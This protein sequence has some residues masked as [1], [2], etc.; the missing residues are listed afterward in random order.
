MFFDDEVVTEGAVGVAFAD[1]ELLPCVS[2]GAAPLG[3]E[4]TVT[5]AEG[6]VISELA[7]R[8]ALRALQTAIE[9]LGDGERALISGGLLLG[10]VIDGGKPEYEQG[11]FL[12]RGLVGADPEKGTVTVGAPVEPGQVVRLHARD[13]ASADLDLRQALALRRA[14]LGGGPPAGAL[15][16]TCNGRG[17]GMFG[18]PHHDAAALLEELAAPCGGFFAAGEIGPVGGQPFVHAFTATVGV[19][20][21]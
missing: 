15:M 13:A 20:A 18:A 7:G 10:V 6:N 5:A 17:R 3:P 1:L 11:D 16:F 8:P 14:A 21:R 4:L 19:F 9:A 12:V 2:Q